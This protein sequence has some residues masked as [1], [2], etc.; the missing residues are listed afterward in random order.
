MSATSD[1]ARSAFVAYAHVLADLEH[2]PKMSAWYSPETL[3]AVEVKRDRL[4]RQVLEWESLA[5]EL[6]RTAIMTAALSERAALYRERAGRL[7]FDL[8]HPSLA[9]HA[10]TD[11]A[12]GALIAYASTIEAVAADLEGS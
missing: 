4:A 6:D 2:L 8:A 10:P 12:A 11:G 7:A 1:R 9:E 5:P 3:A